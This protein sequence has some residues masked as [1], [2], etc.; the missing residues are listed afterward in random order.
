MTQL[1]IVS[2]LSS[3]TEI[4]DARGLARRP[5]KAHGRPPIFDFFDS[6]ISALENLG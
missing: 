5:R 4:A 1:R 6:T 3:A 2:R